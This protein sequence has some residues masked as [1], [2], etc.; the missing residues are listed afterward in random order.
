[1]KIEFEVRNV[2]NE[3]KGVILELDNNRK[4]VKIKKKNEKYFVEIE[5]LGEFDHLFIKNFLKTV[6]Y[7]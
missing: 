5:F 3:L 2:S 1:M 4:A 7:D 6:A